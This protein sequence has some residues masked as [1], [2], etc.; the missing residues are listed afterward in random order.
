MFARPLLV[1]LVAL[2]LLQSPAQAFAERV[3]TDW[4]GGIPESNRL[5]YEVTRK[6]KRHGF[7]VF[8]FSRDAAGNLIV[9]VHI[10]INF[11]FGP[12][13]LFRY[14]HK[15]REVWR[16]GVV[17]SV[18]SRTNNNGEAE[19]ANLQ[20]EGAS[21]IGSGTKYEGQLDDPIMPTSYFNPNFIRQ[22]RFVSTQDGRLMKADV[23]ELGRETLNLP[24]GQV[25]ATRFRLAGKLAID[26]WY[27][28]AGQWVQTEFSRGKNVLL[29][30]QI[31]PA[32]LPPRRDWARP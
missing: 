9:D 26:I 15:N 1:A 17:Q 12:I 21:L 23:E 11:K 14:S 2:A 31:D 5:A 22:T 20:R 29:I 28:D 13:T 7:Q 24:N 18:V 32:T 16:D 30:K 3:S 4:L 10:E 27:T 6:G 19:F 25:E 8:E